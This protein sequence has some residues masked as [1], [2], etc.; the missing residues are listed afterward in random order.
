MALSNTSVKSCKMVK[1]VPKMVPGTV[2]GT[3]YIRLI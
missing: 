2:P 3:I 1:M